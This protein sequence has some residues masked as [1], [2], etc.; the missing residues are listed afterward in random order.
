MR[1]RLYA[2]ASL[3]WVRA[4]KAVVEGHIA[5]IPVGDG[6]WVLNP[7][8]VKHADVNPNAVGRWGARWSLPVWVVVEV[9][10]DVV[11]ACMGREVKYEEVRRIVESH[12][13][14][15]E[16]LKDVLR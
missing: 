5:V 6:V 15:C 2:L 16:E 11:K 9:V 7:L 4:Y 8:W 13:E 1:E 12:R 10:L 3:E 14:I